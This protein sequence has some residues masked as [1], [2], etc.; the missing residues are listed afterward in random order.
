MLSHVA[1]KPLWR[2]NNRDQ[3]SPSLLLRISFWDEP[4]LC[5]AN[6]DENR[7]EV[8]SPAH[9]GTSKRTFIRK[10]K[11]RGNGEKK[12]A[13]TNAATWLEQGSE[14]ASG[15]VTSQ[16]AACW[17]RPRCAAGFLARL[18]PVE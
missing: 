11:F 5:G 2:L 7:D 9:S 14:G 12:A 1:T 3:S 6:P 18:E 13:G 4:D 10:P 16:V 8:S 17:N 15:L